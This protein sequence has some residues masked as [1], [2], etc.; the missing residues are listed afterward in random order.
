MVVVISAVTMT[1]GNF[2]ALAQR[3]FKRMLAYSSI[4]H[5]GY[6]LVGVAAVAVSSDH[7]KSAASVL[8][9]LIIYAFSNIGA[10]AVAAWLARDKGRDDIEDLNGM[11]FAHPG[12]ATCLL[13]LML[14]LIG[15]PPLAGFFGKLYMFM[16]ALKET[17]TGQL[18]FL[19]LVGLGLLN[20]VV[21]AFY[22]VRVLK[23]IFMKPSSRG[24]LGPAP[25]A[26]AL[27]IVLATA[28]VIGFGIFPSAV[29]DDLQDAAVVML[30]STD[31]MQEEPVTRSPG[32][33]A[34]VSDSLAGRDPAV[35]GETRRFASSTP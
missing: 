16:E 33:P 13:L 4:A 10:F 21:S 17:T 30:R 9:Y 7:E 8:F 2:A 23:A 35:R 26:I 1:Y 29:I 19:W 32:T 34:G 22:Y 6:M 15:M 24:A 31:M 12:L 20:S 18:T 28:V 14:S 3:N 5:A 27:P 11:A 25:M